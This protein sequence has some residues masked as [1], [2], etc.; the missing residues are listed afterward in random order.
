MNRLLSLKTSRLSAFIIC[1]AF[2]TTVLFAYAIVLKLYSMLLFLASIFLAIMLL[3]T[4][5]LP[6]F[7]LLILVTFAEWSVELGFLP[8]Q[9]MWAPEI[10]SLLLFFKAGAVRFVQ[11]KKFR[12]PGAKIIMLFLFLA[13][14][15]TLYNRIHI[16]SV[17]LFLR[18]LFRYYLLFLAVLNLDL[19]EKFFRT[20]NR[21]IIFIFLS[22]LPL[23]VVKLIAY[24]QGERPLGLS[25]HYLPAVFPMIAIGFLIALF[26]LY[27]K[28]IIYVLLSLGFVGFSIVGE[29]RAFVF[30]LPILIVYLSRFF[31]K[32]FRS[33]LK[34]AIVGVIILS[35]TVYF[36]ARLI[37]TLNP[38]R[39]VWGEFNPGYLIGYGLDY[40]TKTDE[41]DMAIGRTSATLSAL[42]SLRKKGMMTL[43]FGYGPGSILKS[44][45]ESFDRRSL[46]RAYFG[47]GYGV[48]GIVWL[49]VQVGMIGLV[50]FFSFIYFLLRKSIRYFKNEV[51]PYWRSF[52]FG[53]VG[54]SFIMIFMG[55]LY[56]PIFENDAISAIYFCLAGEMVVRDRALDE[57]GAGDDSNHS[58]GQDGK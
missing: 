39:A 48:N 19:D 49:G 27:Q 24:G 10:L 46:L 58:N 33:V 29:K 22:Q 17:F 12:V 8:P 37:P 34:Y 3:R 28:K 23:S 21:I 9:V 56:H 11:K 36:S 20:L 50:V 57:S 4:N 6:I 32:D 52:G 18:L 14:I 13:I 15:S 16:V 1:L 31:L 30:F 54:F 45:F 53:M 51:D 5:F 44:M 38:Q 2:L 55:L 41:S 35:V 42:D 7:L 40:T 47:V 25:G 43:S 26:F